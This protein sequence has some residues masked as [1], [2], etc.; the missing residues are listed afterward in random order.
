MITFLGSEY[1]SFKLLSFFELDKFVTDFRTPFVKDL[2]I[3]GVTTDSFV[4]EEDLLL[5]VVKYQSETIFVSSAT[6]NHGDSKQCGEFGMPCQS[7][8]VGV[9][10]IIPSRYSQL[11][12][13]EETIINGECDVH[14]VIIRSLESPSTALLH[15]NSTINIHE[16]NLIT[17]SEKVRIESVKFNF[18]QSFSYSGSSIIH[19]ASGQLS[20]SFVDFSSVGESNINQLVVF[21]ST[22]LSIG[23]GILHVDNCSISMLSFKK[24]SFLLNGVEI[25]MTNMKLEHIESTTDVFEIG[26]CGSVVYNGVSAD[27]VKLPDGCIISIGSST[28]GTIYVGSFSFK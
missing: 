8:N 9:Q 11:L 26:D 19:E 20:L 18:D 10:H 5:R 23:K 12:V 2:A 14:D 27:G 16:G 1:S 6:G 24:Y 3:W 4:G 15:L 7:L 21:N 17:T 25:S 28:S 22:L 13:L